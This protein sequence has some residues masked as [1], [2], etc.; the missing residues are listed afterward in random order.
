[1][2]EL[3]SQNHLV[4]TIDW[5]FIYDIC[6]PLYADFGTNRMDYVVL[7]KLLMINVIFGICFI[8]KTCEEVKVNIAYHWFLG[9]SFEDK[10]PNHF[11]FSPL[12]RKLQKTIVVL[13][14]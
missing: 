1:M 4:V 9:L 2:Y 3:L 8:R 12:S 6:D 13:R 11:T 7:F 10:V 5:N 14:L